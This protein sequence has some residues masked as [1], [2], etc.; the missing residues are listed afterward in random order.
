[1]STSEIKTSKGNGA[2]KSAP[3][4][5]T[6]EAATKKPA[7]KKEPK[8]ASQEEIANA[9]AAKNEELEL[10]ELD[11]L[12]VIR[13][14]NVATT[15]EVTLGQLLPGTKRSYHVYKN[16]FGV[17]ETGLTKDELI[18]LNNEL[19]VWDE[20]RK[21]PNP[22]FWQKYSLNLTTS[23]KR[24]RVDQNAK[25]YID[26]KV[27]LTHPDIANSESKLNSRTPF[28]IVD[29]EAEAEQS[30]IEL[31]ALTKAYNYISQMSTTEQ[32][33]F[34]SLLGIPSKDSS[35][36]VAILHLR[37]QAEQS[38]TK[39]VAYYEDGSKKEK[40]IISEMVDYNVLRKSNGAYYYNEV[41]LAVDM[42]AAV[43]WMSDPK[44]QEVKLKLMQQLELAKRRG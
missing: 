14:N 4:S 16:D 8:V 40:V 31:N 36:S 17:Y 25:H 42:L 43:Q 3:A 33:A 7:A 6:L 13:A 15:G 12:I 18:E 34:L 11:R 24:L 21:R 44:N 28:F 37:Q 10:E 20:K 41:L 2:E 35:P 39:F 38:P 22:E 19:P 5:P 32:K 23:E 1:M 9:I 26:W 30:N 27:A 29:E